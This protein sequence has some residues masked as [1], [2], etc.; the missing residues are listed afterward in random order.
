MRDPYRDRFVNGQVAGVIRVCV[1]FTTLFVYTAAVGAA[2]VAFVHGYEEP[3][4]R[5]RFGA[6]YEDYRH[7]VP[8]WRPRRRPWQPGQDHH[9]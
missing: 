9:P 7:A 4:L 5:R 8:A 2:M 6:Q 1:P 3:A